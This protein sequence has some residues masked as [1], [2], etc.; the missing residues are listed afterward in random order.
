MSSPS[1]RKQKKQK[2]RERRVNNEKLAIADRRIYADKFPEFVFQANNSPEG[3]VDL[4]RRTLRGIDF[5][6]RTLFGP[7]EAKFLMQMKLRPQT[8]TPSMMRELAKGNLT[9]M[10]LATMVGQRV[11][12]RIPLEELRQWIPFHDVQ[13]LLN[14]EKIVV[15]LVQRDSWGLVI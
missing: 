8:V 10:H 2:E 6:D 9:A 5:R 7:N 1:A 12:K 14:G 3:F 11:F 15:F 13:F 4:I